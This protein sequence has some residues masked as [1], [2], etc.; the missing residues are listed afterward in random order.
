MTR[1][2]SPCGAGSAG[3]L[4]MTERQPEI[5]VDAD[6]DIN[7]RRRSGRRGPANSVAFTIVIRRRAVRSYAP[8]ETEKAA[9]SAI[10]ASIASIARSVLVSSAIAAAMRC[11][12]C[13]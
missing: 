9:R 2:A 4:V 1:E 3:F 8:L 11:A 12:A 13:R 7:K 6:G 10:I 5:V